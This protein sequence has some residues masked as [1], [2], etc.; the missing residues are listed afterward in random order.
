[1]RKRK[2]SLTEAIYGDYPEA[3]LK[4]INT[5]G[6]CV[7]QGECDCGEICQ[8]G[9]PDCAQCG[10]A[11]KEAVL[12]EEEEILTDDREDTELEENALAGGG[13]AGV[14]GRFGEED[15]LEET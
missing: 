6:V 9:D 3:K 11:L 5:F 2:Y 14:Q 8:C 13:V 7:C 1:M 15:S 10:K 4:P 12:E